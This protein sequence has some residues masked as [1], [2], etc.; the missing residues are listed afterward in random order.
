M[1]LGRHPQLVG[2][3]L[4]VIELRAGCGGS[5]LEQLAERVAEAAEVVLEDALGRRVGALGRGC[6]GARGRR[7][8]GGW[9]HSVYLRCVYLCCTTYLLTYL[10][11][12]VYT[13]LTH[14]VH[15]RRAGCARATT[16]TM[17]TGYHHC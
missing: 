13:G 2:R 12:S 1:G 9:A 5:E 15:S 16:T 8:V 10:L 3:D 4:G 6:R 14:G 7:E 17:T 11:T